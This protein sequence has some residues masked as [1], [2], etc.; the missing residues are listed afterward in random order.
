MKA[1][2]KNLLLEFSKSEL[3]YVFDRALELPVLPKSVRK[4][5]VLIGMRRVGK[6]FLMYRHMKDLISNGL[7]KQKILYLNFE[8]DR[9]EDFTSKDFQ[10]ILDVYF[11]LYPE[12]ANVDDLYFYFD[13]I[14]NVEGWE[15]FIRRLIDKEKIKIFIT[16]SSS[17]SLS[18]EI[19]TSLRGRCLPIEIFPLSFSEFLNYHKIQY[20]LN[21]TS[22]EESIIRHYFHNYL[23]Y[24]G[25]P[26]IL[27]IS[28]NNL[29]QKII[30]TYVNTAIFRDVIERYKLNK[31][32]II[33][34]FL[35]HCL[36]N[37]ASSLSVT[38]IY[39]A[40]KSRGEILSRQS[41]YEYLDY[42]ID[43]YLICSIP[44][45]DLSTRKRQVN[46]NKI[47][48][49]DSGIINA[50]SIKPN[51]EYSSSLENLVYIH[52][53]K[54]YYENIFYYKTKSGKEVDF[55]VQ[56]DNGEILIYQVCY[57][58]MNQST[59]KRE[60]DAIKESCLEMKMNKAS[61]ITSDY[62]EELKLN[63][64]TINFISYWK[65]SLD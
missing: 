25:F 51:M 47:Y 31:P 59:R 42:F 45:F 63:D 27:G 33:K 10:K 24:G 61:I 7:E 65:W 23:K 20:G 22:K 43:A 21:L 41:L 13:E 2:I 35:L 36:Q 38:K 28:N 44:I 12:Y 19:A 11:E 50:Y 16:G 48:C 6:T 55:I 14:Q 29:S 40:L 54:K 5:I 26:E 37:I 32:H 62:D 49:I 3:P 1:V 30:Q 60:L 18:K 58:I 53:R 9:L 64:L 17:K 34:L 57:D 15:K 4:A 52:L 39:K 8:D 46:P 56:K